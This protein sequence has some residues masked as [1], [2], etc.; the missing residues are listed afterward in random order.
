MWT[1]TWLNWFGWMYGLHQPGLFGEISEICP[2][3]KFVDGFRKDVIIDMVEKDE[4]CTVVLDDLN[5]QAFSNDF[6][7]A[8][9]DGISHNFKINLIVISQNLFDKGKWFRHAMLNTR[10]L[11]LMSSVKDRS[12]AAA[13][14]HSRLFTIQRQRLL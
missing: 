1:H 10:H 8:L 13:A 12:A 14:F 4:R 6:F 11:V 5:R 2:E 3:S 7:A 9:F